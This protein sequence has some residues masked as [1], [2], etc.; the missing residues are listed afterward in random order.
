MVPMTILQNLHKD[1][2]FYGLDDLVSMTEKEIERITPKAKEEDDDSYTI[3]TRDRACRLFP[4]VHPIPKSVLPEYLEHFKKGDLL[5]QDRDWLF[6][7]YRD[8]ALVTWNSRDY[9]YAILKGYSEDDKTTLTSTSQIDETPDTV[10]TT[11]IQQAPP[12]PSIPPPNQLSLD[13]LRPAWA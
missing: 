5:L 7:R 10:T 8:K 12:P 13:H 1:A 2:L 6:T 11:R 3:V 9:C 4:R